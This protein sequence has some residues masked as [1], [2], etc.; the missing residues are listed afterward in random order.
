MVA[1]NQRFMRSSQ[2]ARKIIQSGK[3]G[4]IRAVRADVMQ[5]LPAMLPPPHWL[6]DGE[7]AG[8]G[9]VISAAVHRI[10]LLRYLVGEVKQVTAICHTVNPVFTHNAEDYAWAILEF[11]NGACGELFA[12]YSGFCLPWGESLMIFGDDGTLHSVPPPGHYFG[13]TK[14]V[15]KGDL[16]LS[17]ILPE[18]PY[19]GFHSIDHIDSN[20]LSED[21]FINQM[22]HFIECCQIGAEAISSGRDNLGTMKV[23]FGI[24]ESA[25]TGQPVKL[26]SREVL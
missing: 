24:Y 14:L 2:R 17:H 10:D 23:V 3:L 4:Q 21:S 7:E 16:A 15:S 6:Y 11:E 25:R 18:N 8:G 5:N 1:Q 13:D 9:V 20:L 22:K 19:R 26:H 12:T